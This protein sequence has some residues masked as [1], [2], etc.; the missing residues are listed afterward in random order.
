MGLKKFLLALLVSMAAISPAH[1]NTIWKSSTS[2]SDPAAETELLKFFVENK[3]VVGANVDTNAIANV[4]YDEARENG[5][6]NTLTELSSPAFLTTFHAEWK[7]GFRKKYRLT[8]N[9]ISWDVFKQVGRQYGGYTICDQADNKVFIQVVKD[10]QQVVLIQQQ[11]QAL[12]SAPMTP[13]NEAKSDALAALAKDL[14][15]KIAGNKTAIG[16]HDKLILGL[17]TD[18]D[19]LTGEVGN[20]KT[21]VVGRLDKLET[22]LTQVK[23]ST[24]ANTQTLTTL[25]GLPAKVDEFGKIVAAADATLNPPDGKPL[26]TRVGEVE[27][28][29]KE[30]ANTSFI[31]GIIS[32]LN[33]TTIIGVFIALAIGG[34]LV[35]ILLTQNQ[36][37]RNPRPDKMAK[38]GHMP[39]GGKSAHS[40]LEPAGQSD[41]AKA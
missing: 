15:D 25:N 17:R 18:V 13:A 26:G 6:F 5:C 36:V 16:N 24:E 11:Q 19:K 27:E 20:L 12:A 4:A 40:V 14:E 2:G 38:G 23:T 29:L 7:A 41:K 34:L 22:S 9:T 39:N 28:S 21:E 8:A 32:Q 30:K 3:V 1:A 10:K 33:I 37:E 35:R 31:D